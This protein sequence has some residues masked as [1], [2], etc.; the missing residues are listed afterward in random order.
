VFAQ[1]FSQ[2]RV[3]IV[4]TWGFWNNYTRALEGDGQPEGLCGREGGVHS[5]GLCKLGRRELVYLNYHGCI[6]SYERLNVDWFFNPSDT[7]EPSLWIHSPGLGVTL[8]LRQG[9]KVSMVRWNILGLQQVGV[10]F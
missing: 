3:S 9:T 5:L 8:M 7:L 4:P 10:L 2:L 1:Y 6:K